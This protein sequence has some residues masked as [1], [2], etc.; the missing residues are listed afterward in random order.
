MDFFRTQ[1]GLARRYVVFNVE[2]LLIFILRRIEG[3]G[4][5]S[6]C[7]RNKGLLLTVREEL[8]IVRS[9]LDGEKGS[10]IVPGIRQL[11]ELTVT[12]TQLPLVVENCME[13]FEEKLLLVATSHLQMLKVL[14]KRAL[15]GL[16]VNDLPKDVVGLAVAAVKQAA[17]PQDMVNFSAVESAIKSEVEKFCQML[18]QK[19]VNQVT[20]Q[21]PLQAKNKSGNSQPGHVSSSLTSNERIQLGLKQVSPACTSQAPLV[22][23][24]SSSS[25]PCPVEEFS[26][27]A[28]TQVFP[29]QSSVTPWV[30]SPSEVRPKPPSVITRV[31]SPSEVRQRPL[32]VTTG[33][34]VS[35]SE[36]CHKPPSVTTWV[37]SSSKVHHKPPSVT[38]LVSSSS[39]IRDK[40]PSVTTWVSSSEVLHK[41]PSG[42]TWVS[43][44]SEVLQ[45]SDCQPTGK[46]WSVSIYPPLVSLKPPVVS[47]QISPSLA[48]CQ[49]AENLSS[50]P[51]RYRYPHLPSS[52]SF[53]EKREQLF[54][55]LSPRRFPN[56]KYW[57][58]V[59]EPGLDDLSLQVPD[60]DHRSHLCNPP[61]REASIASH[62]FVSS[63]AEIWSSNCTVIKY[64]RDLSLFR[65][66]H[67]V[68]S[69]ISP[70]TS[71]RTFLTTPAASTVQMCASRHHM[72]KSVGLTTTDKHKLRELKKEMV[73]LV[74]TDQHESRDLQEDPARIELSESRDMKGEIVDLAKVHLRE[75]KELKEEVVDLNMTAQHE[76]KELK[77]EIGNMATLGLHE[78]IE[79]KEKIVGVPT[80]DQQDS[81]VNL[82]KIDE[83]DLE[84]LKQE[85]DQ[86]ESREL[87]PEIVHLGLPVTDQHESRELKQEIGDF[88]TTHQHDSVELNKEIMNLVTKDQQESRELKSE[89]V[90]LDTTDQQQSRELKSEIVNLD[91]TDKLGSRELKQEIGNLASDQYIS[92]DLKQEM[93]KTGM[94]GPKIEIDIEETLSFS[95]LSVS[96]DSGGS[97]VP[98]AADYCSHQQRP[99][100]VQLKNI[101]HHPHW[102]HLVRKLWRQQILAG[103][104][105]LNPVFLILRLLDP[106]PC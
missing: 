49:F 83:Q 80:T 1:A 61:V 22:V 64:H 40:P 17:G 10:F 91:T 58:G 35:S 70:S 56:G 99:C 78:F 48:A 96:K 100:E 5:L 88:S 9:L 28:R 66:S 101:A 27:F 38:T 41:P 97:A 7:T 39:E 50:E 77:E 13:Q 25:A 4:V 52:K 16:T 24:P 75:S 102:G 87:K 3:R 57:E 73:D 54:G 94:E 63:E 11:K 82:V 37:S 14:N 2:L 98:W 31:S 60:F 51:Y 68:Q 89:I 67:G 81:D 62:A 23:A 18:V 84:A 106:D 20:P 69:Q 46:T 65:P 95:W 8:I 42:T 103:K 105:Y 55:N 32:S 74:T 34:W 79:L 76:P 43:S 21:G 92:G 26:S 15:A 6:P 19:S 33:T 86:Q 45:G 93:S 30:S 90:Y 29:E 72:Q 12:A 71:P 59:R 104:L 36:V 85:S 53:D 44:S 47:A